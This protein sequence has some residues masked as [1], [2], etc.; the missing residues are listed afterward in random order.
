MLWKPIFTISSPRPN[1]YFALELLSQQNRILAGMEF[2]K[3]ELVNCKGKDKKLCSYQISC[4]DVLY[5]EVGDYTLQ[6][7]DSDLTYK[8]VKNGGDEPVVECKAPKVLKNGKCVEPEITC[9]ED[10]TSN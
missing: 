6:V 3:D 4:G 8:L 1:V 7:N 10:H 5:S 9:G 2:S